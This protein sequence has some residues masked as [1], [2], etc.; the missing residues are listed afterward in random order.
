MNDGYCETDSEVIF[1]E[2]L[3]QEF[4]EGIPEQIKDMRSF[5]TEGELDEVTR[6]AHDIKGTAGVFDMDEGSDIALSLQVASA[7][8]RLE[9]CVVLVEKLAC[10][11]RAKG[12][13]I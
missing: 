13:S 4:L 12:A 9:D 6:I 2:D 10:Y 8:D 5:L 3:K 11:M 7:E 1:M